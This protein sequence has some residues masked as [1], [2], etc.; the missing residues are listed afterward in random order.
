MM[1]QDCVL[2]VSECV[3]D[4]LGTRATIVIKF[5]VLSETYNLVPCLPWQPFFPGCVVSEV[6]TFSAVS[7]GFLFGNIWVR[8]KN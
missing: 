3:S 4:T 1:W 2:W 8:L 6:E 7:T 5:I